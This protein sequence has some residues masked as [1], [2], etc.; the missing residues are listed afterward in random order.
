MAKK[1]SKSSHTKLSQ[2]PATAISG[3]DILSSVLY[4]SG[5]AALFAGVFAPIIILII[6]IV[7]YFYK[8]VYTEAVEALPVNGGAYNCLLNASSKVLASVAGSM[9]I[10]SYIATAVISAKVGI[11]YVHSLVHIPVIPMTI[12]LLLVFALLV[13]SGIK[14]SA[15]VAIAIF[16]THVITLS[17]FLVLGVIYI[18]NHGTGIL[19][20]NYVETTKLIVQ[21]G[22]I[23]KTLF[24]AFAVSL[25]GV[26][27]FESSANFVEEQKKGVFRKTLR[28]MLIGVA[29]FSPIVAF[30]VLNSLPFET[31]ISAS[32]FLLAYAA[33]V[34]GGTIF[35]YWLVVD[36]FLV[37]SGAV[38]TA[39]IGASGLIN[40]MAADDCLPGFL[41]HQNKKGSYPRIII[42][43]FIL[44]SSILILTG[45]N[46][47]SL[48]GVYTISFLGVMTL[49][50]TGNLMLRRT[51][52]EL[53]RTY[54]AP[55]LYVILA[56]TATSAGIVGNILIE[57]KNFVFFL[58]YFVPTMLIV[59]SII[60]KEYFLRALMRFLTPFPRI[61][62]KLYKAFD[63]AI[64]GNFVV[65]I[66]NTERLYT[67]LNYLNNNEVGRN[68]YV[69]VCKEAKDSEQK[70]A[71]SD[72]KQ[73]LPLLQ[74]S[75]VF[76]HLNLKLIRRK[77]EFGPKA[78]KAVSKE[79]GIPKNRI[80]IGSIHHHHDFDYDDFGGVRIVF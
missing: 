70:S 50:A 73:A 55:F 46:L 76:P 24:F 15:N 78:V 23:V 12:G 7:L 48:A 49:F 3:N 53:K 69:V 41:T 60:Y 63:D 45:G 14:D 75:G 74:K 79:L 52:T 58:T 19:Q 22:G 64:D 61:K 21:N 33:E 42:A 31:I 26:S 34:I 65:F 59:L 5:I 72:I 18:A 40:R 80:L 38:L 2:L 44:C 25:L 16:A 28:N 62:S 29:F 47:L 4:V 9:T 11:E 54:N 68:I 57:P 67:A 77:E 27:G 56:G 6:G 20:A 36:A 39:Y 37:L 30:L 17:A 1:H 10:L 43:F 35:K 32:D 8:S 71:Y 66:R 13:I 51:R